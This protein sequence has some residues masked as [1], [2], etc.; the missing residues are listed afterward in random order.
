MLAEKQV[1]GEWEM[2]SSIL[3]VAFDAC[4]NIMSRYDVVS[5]DGKNSVDKYL[6]LVSI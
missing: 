3:D 6:G 4:R 2:G 5:G 1:F